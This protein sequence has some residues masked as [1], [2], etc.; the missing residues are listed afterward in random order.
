M[1]TRGDK[2]GRARWQ[3]GGPTDSQAEDSHRPGKG[4]FADAANAAGC[5]FKQ[6]GFRSDTRKNCSTDKSCSGAPGSLCVCRG[7]GRVGQ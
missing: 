4:L 7:R 1:W 6:D 5:T 3:V 2:Q